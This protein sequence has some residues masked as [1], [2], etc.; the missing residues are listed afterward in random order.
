MLWRMTPQPKRVEK[1]NQG[2]LQT[3]KNKNTF[4][5]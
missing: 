2:K 3:T 5:I 4:E 1:L